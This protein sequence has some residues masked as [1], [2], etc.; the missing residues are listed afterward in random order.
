MSR[1]EWDYELSRKII[2]QFSNSD[3]MA[4][5]LPMRHERTGGGGTAE[6]MPR[7]E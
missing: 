2:G 5:R 6:S 3:G 4:I 1:S 7:M